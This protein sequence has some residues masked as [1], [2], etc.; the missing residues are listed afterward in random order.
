MHTHRV[1]RAIVAER[2]LL[3]LISGQMKIINLPADARLFRMYQDSALLSFVLLIESESFQKVKEG[4][5]PPLFFFHYEV[6]PKGKTLEELNMLSPNYKS[7][8]CRCELTAPETV[9]DPAIEAEHAK[10]MQKYCENFPPLK[11]EVTTMGQEIKVKKLPIGLPSQGSPYLSQAEPAKDMTNP[12]DSLAGE[13]LERQGER[14]RELGNDP[15]IR[16]MADGSFW[17]SGIEDGEWRTWKGP[18]ETSEE[19]LAAMKAAQGPDPIDTVCEH[20]KVMDLKVPESKTS[21]LEE[22]L[23]IP[24]RKIE[25]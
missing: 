17:Y 14:C 16:R 3:E 21:A 25:L 11:W 23:G 1:V 18:Y 5:E 19:C 6:T 13:A 7:P 9:P 4:E 22:F 12:P 8:N 2:N 10:L 15:E 20:M 24:M